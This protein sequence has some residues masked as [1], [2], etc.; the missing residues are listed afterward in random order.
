MTS[1]KEGSLGGTLYALLM[2]G[3]VD[4][5]PCGDRWAIRPPPPF[6]SH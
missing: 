1:R 5:F 6:E 3:T 2:D 4:D